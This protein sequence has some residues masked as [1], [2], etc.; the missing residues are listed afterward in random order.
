MV[1]L[2]SVRILADQS[3][4]IETRHGSQAHLR[5][6]EYGSKVGPQNMY[7]HALQQENE[8]YKVCES[9]RSIELRFLF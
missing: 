1:P 7:R 8:H 3:Y 2:I 6:A 9:Q 5:D 4:G